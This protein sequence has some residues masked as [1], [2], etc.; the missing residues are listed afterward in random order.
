MKADGKQRVL[1]AI[2]NHGISNENYVR[3]LI[4]EYRTFRRDVDIVILSDVEK[5]LG[6]DIEVLVGV[7]TDNPWSLPFAHKSLF[8]ERQLDYDL[9]IYSEDD[10]LITEENIDA[11]L[12]A[13]DV[14]PPDHIAGF[15]RYEIAK[16]GSWHFSTV[17]GPY[18]WEPESVFVADG[19]VFAHLTN[20]HSA[21]FILTREKLKVCIDSGGFLCEAHEGRYDMLCSAATD[22]YTRCGLKKVICVSQIAK[23]SLHHLP[24][25]YIGRMGIPKTE[26][27]LQLKRIVSLA[28]NDTPRSS[29]ISSRANVSFSSRYDRDY[30]TPA[31]ASVVRGMPTQSCRVLSIGCDRGLTEQALQQAGHMVEAIPLDTIVA[32]SARMRGVKILELDLEERSLATFSN[33][34]DFILFNFCL[35]YFP[36]PVALLKN[37]TPALADGG[38]F[39]VVFRNWLALSEQRRRWIERQQWPEAAAIGNYARSG[40]HRTDLPIVRQWLMAAGFDI[41]RSVYDIPRK[42]SRFSLQDGAPIGRWLAVTGTAISIPKGRSSLVATCE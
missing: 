37:L 42:Y 27:D 15:L 21:A 26:M 23:F 30:C 19:K 3:R 6:E 22:P 25:K 9:F 38:R 8:E 29:L 4:D 32:E 24:N 28:A 13:E 33:R 40:V 18:H 16:D 11:F 7:P 10:T 39:A 41:E 36:D 12:D 34:Y 1:V 20:E 17:H 5:S 31:T 14:L 2:A 35:P